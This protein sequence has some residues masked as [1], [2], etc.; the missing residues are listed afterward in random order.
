MI[1]RCVGQARFLR[2]EA[3]MR[4][5]S[6]SRALSSFL[7]SLEGVKS[8][9]TIAW[10]RQRLA[11]LEAQ[12]GQKRIDQVSI[13]DLRSWR[14]SFSQRDNFSAWTLHGH[15]RAARRLFAWLVQE[16]RLKVSPAK[17]LEL[18]RLTYEPRKGIE[19]GDMLKMI[20]AARD[21]P[22]DYAL[23]LFLADSACRCGGVASLRVGELELAR[24]RATVCE[25][26]SKSRQ[27]FL[28]QRTC[29]ALRS[30]LKG[31]SSGPVFLNQWTGRALK[32][33][34]IYQVLKR[35][36]I[37]AG[38]TERWN[39]HNWRH[40]AARGMLR[41]GANL[42]QVSQILGHSDVSVTVKFYGSFVDDEL[43]AAHT[44][45][46]WLPVEDK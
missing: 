16:G 23:V 45:Y 39:P 11:G 46:G 18:P 21:S 30:Y 22:R 41:R 19:Y 1:A 36:A 14:A 35:L 31:R 43:K 7:L 17:R 27:V 24:G 6:V 34:G 5:M 40:G 28:Q 2:L 8:P 33:G 20:T 44:R 29:D 12:L 37:C 32:P 4:G 26:G 38:V 10:Y 3:L 13:S 25:K 42:A 15:V 9:A